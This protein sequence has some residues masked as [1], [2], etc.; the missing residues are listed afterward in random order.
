MVLMSTAVFIG[1][2]HTFIGVDHYIPFVVLSK[3]N[4]WSLRKTMWIVLVC[5]IGHVLSSA[6]F[7]YFGI[8]LSQSVTYL[9]DI[10]SIRGSLATYFMI[11][12]G[13]VYT[14]W[15][16]RDIYLH[17]PHKH[18]VDGHE[19]MHDHHT[20]ESTETHIDEKP[21]SNQN[22]IWGLFILF[23]LG[24]CEPLIPLLMYPAATENTGA[25]IGVTL[26]FSFCTI[27][28]MLLLTWIGIKG[29]SIIKVN[30]LDKYSHALAGSAITICGLMILTLGI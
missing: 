6:V 27:S 11:G 2:F 4:A 30:F 8:L 17:K 29:L 20:I 14:L 18:M 12:F 9:V 23:V 21:K 19:I 3:A 26:A 28:M 7:G 25:L 24:P 1:L 15:A 10:E 16:L 13:L 22:V 5:G